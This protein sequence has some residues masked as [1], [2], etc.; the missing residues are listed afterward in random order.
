MCLEQIAKFCL[1]GEKDVDSHSESRIMPMSHEL[2]ETVDTLPILGVHF[3]C[4]SFVSSFASV[5]RLDCLDCF[6]TRL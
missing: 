6:K 1:V 4:F 5:Y 2:F 3:A